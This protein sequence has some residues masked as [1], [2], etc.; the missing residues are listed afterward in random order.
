[1]TD[2]IL[3]EEYTETTE[4]VEVSA[5]RPFLSTPLDDYTVTEGLLLMILL[6]FVLQ[7]VFR[8]LK[9]GFSWLR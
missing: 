8:I 4:V 1:M 6:C 3:T 5:D 7:F 9:G 2:E